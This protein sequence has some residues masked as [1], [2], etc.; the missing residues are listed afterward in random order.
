LL[1][2]TD[3]ILDMLRTAVNVFSDSCCAVV[4]A[5]SEGETLFAPDDLPESDIRA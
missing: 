4:I 2:V 1:M 5:S 3:R